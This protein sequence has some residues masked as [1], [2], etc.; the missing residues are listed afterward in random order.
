M[1]TLSTKLAGKQSES[2][3]LALS[4]CENV[5]MTKLC[6]KVTAVKWNYLNLRTKLD[7]PASKGRPGAPTWIT[8]GILA[9]P[10]SPQGNKGLCSF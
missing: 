9:Q 10:T 7:L 6:E 8:F 1:K 4:E 2:D 5:R 3:K